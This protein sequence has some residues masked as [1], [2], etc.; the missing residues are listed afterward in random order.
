[1]LTIDP[2][3]TVEYILICSAFIFIV[4]RTIPTPHPTRHA[5]LQKSSE[6]SRNMEKQNL[7]LHS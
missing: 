5:S 3:I 6:I 7:L 1:M 4:F 2:G